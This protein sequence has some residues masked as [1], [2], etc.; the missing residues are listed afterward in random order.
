MNNINVNICII[1]DIRNP[2]FY[3]AENANHSSFMLRY[4]V[5]VSNMKIFSKD[6]YRQKKEE[7]LRTKRNGS[8]SRMLVFSL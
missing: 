8:F 5:R 2:H 1:I 7:L 6:F 4:Y 3:C